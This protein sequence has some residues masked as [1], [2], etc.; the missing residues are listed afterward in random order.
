[1]ATG[2]RITD[3]RK[4]TRSHC[5]V[6]AECRKSGERD[7]HAIRLDNIS[8]G[9]MGFFSDAQYT[10]G[11]TVEVRLPKLSE[12]TPVRCSVRWL[13]QPGKSGGPAL[14]GA[15][16]L[17]ISAEHHFEVVETLR[18]IEAWRE[19]MQHLKKTNIS[20]AEAVEQWLNEHD[21]VARKS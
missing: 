6:D 8:D 4:H 2:E 14:H 21:T 3:E 15:Q 19:V 10:P 5:E 17:P 12:S 20:T 1:M 9:G 7:W 13:V 16:V 18:H 11:Q